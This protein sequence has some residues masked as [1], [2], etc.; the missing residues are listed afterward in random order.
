MISIKSQ[1]YRKVLYESKTKKSDR[2]T[3]YLSD[4]GSSHHTDIDIDTY[5]QSDRNSK[6]THPMNV[7]QEIQRINQAELDQKLTN[8]PGSWHA[9]YSNSAW[10]YVGG[11]YSLIVKSTT[12]N[13]RHEVQT[14]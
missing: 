10:V 6:S 12:Q 3:S 7:I 4:C 9:K 5:D 13:K 8:T 2:R 1:P 11:L 14:T